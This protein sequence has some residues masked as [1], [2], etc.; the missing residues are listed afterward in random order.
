MPTTVRLTEAQSAYVADKIED[1]TYESVEEATRCA[2]DLLREED[3]VKLAWLREA[4]AE[5]EASGIYGPVDFEALKAEAKSRS[6]R[7]RA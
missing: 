7:K 6:A 3:A 4:V 5:G 1:G 2:F